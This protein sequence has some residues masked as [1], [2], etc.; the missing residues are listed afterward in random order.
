MS[1]GIDPIVS[2][3][4]FTLSLIP[5][6]SKPMAGQVY[7]GMRQDLPCI[8]VLIPLFREKQGDIEIT[9]AS[10][11]SQTFPRRKLEVILIVEPED[12]ETSGSLGTSIDIH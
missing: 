9:L 7:E 6:L 4:F 11:K 2:N 12:N 8:S 10:L 3:L 5:H 1:L